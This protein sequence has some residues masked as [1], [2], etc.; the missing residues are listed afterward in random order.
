MLAYSQVD[1]EYYS[2]HSD[3]VDENLLENLHGRTHVFYDLWNFPCI[4]KRALMIPRVVPILSWQTSFFW[5][6]SLAIKCF[7]TNYVLLLTLRLILPT[8][9]YLLFG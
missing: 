8:T 9:Y 3:G 7:I 2:E 1:Q 6:F 5:P 4:P